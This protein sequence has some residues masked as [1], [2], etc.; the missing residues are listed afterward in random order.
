MKLKERVFDDE[1]ALRITYPKVAKLMDEY[2]KEQ[3]EELSFGEFIVYP[4]WEDTE[5][6]NSYTRFELYGYVT[7]DEDVSYLIE[8]KLIGSAPFVMEQSGLERD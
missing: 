8:G 2:H 6:G 5:G 3:D 1:E 7:D 4:E